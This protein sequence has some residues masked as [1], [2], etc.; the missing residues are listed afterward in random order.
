MKTFLE[1]LAEAEQLRESE[2]PAEHID[3]VVGMEK[4]PKLQSSDP[5][6][7]WIFA[8][9]IA[10]AHGSDKSKDFEAGF[11]KSGPVGQSLTVAPYTEEEH[12]MVKVTKNTM[13]TPSVQVSARGSKETSDTH[14]VSPHRNPGAVKLKRK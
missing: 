4:F 3:A 6:D 14:K 11:N 2:I 7:A 5:Y 10:G 13:G 9:G 12:R 8:K 1:Y